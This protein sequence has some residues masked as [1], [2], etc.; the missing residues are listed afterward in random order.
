M[1]TTDILYNGLQ[2]YRTL[3]AVRSAITAT[4]DLLVIFIVTDWCHLS[5]VLDGE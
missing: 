2:Q 3:Y 4:A 1:L 5:T